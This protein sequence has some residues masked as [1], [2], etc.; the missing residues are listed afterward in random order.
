MKIL[1]LS[2]YPPIQGGTSSRCYFHYRLL[3]EAGH[4]V[5]VVT[6]AAEVEA[7]YRCRLLPGDDERLTASFPS[8]GEVRVVFSDRRSVEG[9]FV[10]AGDASVTRLAALS[11]QVQEAFSPD[12]IFCSYL[13]PYGMAAALVA[14]WTGLPYVLEHAGSD[15]TRLLANPELGPALARVVGGAAVCFSGDRS[16]A[17]F[18]VAPDRIHPVV[19]SYLPTDLFSPVGPTMS[20]L[21]GRPVVGIYGKVGVTKGSFDLL[22]ALDRLRADGVEFE[23]AAM[24][25]GRALGAFERRLLAGAVGAVTRRLPFLCPWQVPAFLRSCAIVCFL[26]RDFP[27]RIHGPKVAREVLATG[28]CLVVSEEIRRKQRNAERFVDGENVVLVPDPRQVSELA[29]C[30]RGPILDPARAAEVGRA[31]HELFEPTDPALVVAGYEEALTRAATRATPA[32]VRRPTAR[33]NGDRD[34][35][36]PDDYPAS[37]AVLTCAT[38]ATALRAPDDDEAV[39]VALLR[40]A[41]D[42]GPDS[43]SWWRDILRYDAARAW[44]RRAPTWPVSARGVEVSDPVGEPAP[45]DL[46][47]ELTA[48]MK[49][50]SFAVD[51]HQA[52]AALRDGAHP[53]QLS[54]RPEPTTLL[55]VKSGD[56]L[57]GVYRIS[58]SAAAVIPAIDGSST[59]GQI[60]ERAGVRPEHLAAL[61]SAFEAEN[62]LRVHVSAPPGPPFADDA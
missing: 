43:P 33:A 31:G 47:P 21:S 2:K 41:E 25:G 38:V 3:A 28:R 40:A 46:Y 17:G 61:L 4:Q 32:P 44:L 48:P 26:E 58:S 29:R 9:Q 56:L 15:R 49:V 55:F 30:L 51:V 12:V 52:E 39:D 22:A 60:C 35:I 20:A 14:G 10:P 23:L 5:V 50:L 37:H 13:E 53:G 59:V 19:P 36:P 62:A 16:L 34:V 18:G 1:A 42:L 45:R 27:V 57:G 6:N 8:G 7:E 11:L 24:V 54:P